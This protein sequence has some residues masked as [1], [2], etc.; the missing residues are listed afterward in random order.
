MCTILITMCYNVFHGPGLKTSPDIL[1]IRK[2]LTH[3][4]FELS[5]AGRVWLRFVEFVSGGGGCGGGGEEG[6][7]KINLYLVQME[8]LLHFNVGDE[9]FLYLLSTSH[10]AYKH[11]M[12]LWF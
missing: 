6:L 7:Y 8:I 11:I 3:G 12:Y 9:Q 5:L 10:L 2:A 1:F 4:L